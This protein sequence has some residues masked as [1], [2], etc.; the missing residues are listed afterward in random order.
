MSQG[1]YNQSV[2]AAAM[3]FNDGRLTDSQSLRIECPELGVEF[4]DGMFIGTDPNG[5]LFFNDFDEF[6]LDP[7]GTHNYTISKVVYKDKPYIVIDLNHKLDPHAYAKFVAEDPKNAVDKN[8]MDGYSN[9]AH[10]VKLTVGS[11][12]ATI[13]KTIASSTITLSAPAI[14]K[15]A[16]WSID[17]ILPCPEGSNPQPSNLV[18]QAFT[19]KGNLYFRDLFK[20]HH[21][22]CANYDNDRVVFYYDGEQTGFYAYFIPLEIEAQTL[23]D[24][25]GEF[26]SGVTWGD[27]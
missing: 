18:N 10:W 23:G 12:A 9:T 7:N 22:E 26:F 20:L 21:G 11:S 6:E 16:T 14:R 17:S 2:S 8:K 5:R 19:V 13:E 25:T 4:T 1:T 3:L 27:K 24:P 15:Q